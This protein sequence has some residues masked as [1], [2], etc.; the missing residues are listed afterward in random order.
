LTPLAR[1][2][3]TGFGIAGLKAAMDLSGM[4]GGDP[5]APLAS[6]TGEAVERIRTLL[7]ATN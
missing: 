1:A 7:N 5:R 2:V 4:S 3:T 6:L